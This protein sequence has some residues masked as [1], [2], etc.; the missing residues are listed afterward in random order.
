MR[1]VVAQ[2]VLIAA[3]VVGCATL[4]HPHA[5]L[6]EALG[7]AMVIG[8]VALLTLAARAMGRSFT[9]LPTPRPDGALVTGG[10]YRMVRH[11]VY[12]AG[13]LALAGACVA[14]AP[15]AGIGVAALAALWWQK[16]SLEERHL[17][18]RFPEYA[19]YAARV[20]ARLVPW[21]L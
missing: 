3:I 21:L 13:L 18:A 19:A 10:P 9:A 16:S 20:R 17:R 4:P 14:L 1:Y 2:T 7:A 6:A 15:S 11:P 12:A 5:L 8:G